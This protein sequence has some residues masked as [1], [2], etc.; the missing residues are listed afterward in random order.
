MLL[1]QRTKLGRRRTEAVAEEAAVVAV[2]AVVV[3]EEDAEGDVAG[4]AVGSEMDP[5]IRIDLQE[6]YEPRT[7]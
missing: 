6:L 7:E 5:S 4:V 2:V 3:A 1:N